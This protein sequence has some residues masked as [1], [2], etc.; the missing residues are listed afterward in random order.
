MDEQK[1]PSEDKDAPG[2]RMAECCVCVCGWGGVLV[3][4]PPT[5]WGGGV[6]PCVC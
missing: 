2:E 4:C 6:P 3:L 1:P 5:P